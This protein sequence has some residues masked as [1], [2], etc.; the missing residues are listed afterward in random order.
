MSVL[1]FVQDVTVK[2]ALYPLL[3]LLE[4]CFWCSILTWGNTCLL[5][6]WLMCS[7]KID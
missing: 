6:M 2:A 3:K 4:V 5:L 7:V 1:A